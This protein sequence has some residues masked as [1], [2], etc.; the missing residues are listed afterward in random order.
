LYLRPHEEFGGNAENPLLENTCDLATVSGKSCGCPGGGLA[1]ALMMYLECD[2]QF[3]YIC[4]FGA[5]LN[6]FFGV[7][8]LS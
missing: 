3:Y 5:H 6:N 8:Y 2:S 1:L 4:G 7:F